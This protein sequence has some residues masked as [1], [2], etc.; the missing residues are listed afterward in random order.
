MAHID[1]LP[2]EQIDPDVQKIMQTYDT[3]YGGSEFVQVFAHAPEVYK[4]FC[5]Y[6]FPLI[7]ETRGSLDMKLTELV[8]LKVAQ[9][10]D[11]AL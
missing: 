1:S 4:A 7:F 11:C 6:Y 2:F 9:R 8:R 3:E 10:N 5:A